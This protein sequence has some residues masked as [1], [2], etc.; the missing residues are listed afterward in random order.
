MQLNYL[1]WAW[2]LE[3]VIDAAEFL[4]RQREE[5]YARTA[6]NDFEENCNTTSFPFFSFQVH[7][8]ENVM[9]EYLALCYDLE[10]VNYD[11]LV[12]RPLTI[13]FDP[14]SFK[15]L[16]FVKTFLSDVLFTYLS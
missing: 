1:S 12:R 15:I 10:L 6:K 2:M 5:R 14:S 11:N 9:V 16:S 3:S 8:A 4:K 7:I 13:Y